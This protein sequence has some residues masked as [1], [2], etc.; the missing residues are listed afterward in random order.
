LDILK[1]EPLDRIETVHNFID[2]KD[3]VI[4]KGAVRSY[5]G[6]RF[7]LPFNMKDGIL[8]CEGKSNSEWNF[9]APHGA[10]RVLS[11]NQA[12]KSLNMENF[13]KQMEGIFST[14]IGYG[15]LD[16]SPLAYKNCS[17]IE[18]AIKPTST[19]IERIRPILNM[20]NMEMENE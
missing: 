9:S 8:I 2:F 4:R 1:K 15:T 6:E 16:E 10:G 12:K 17:L 5:I 3:F 20:K 7:C 11:R 19:I 18:E 14:S 13:K